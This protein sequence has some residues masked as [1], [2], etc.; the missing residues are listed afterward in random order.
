MKYGIRKFTPTWAKL[1]PTQA[2]CKFHGE[3]FDVYQWPQ[4]MFDG[5]TATFEL[6]RRQDTVTTIAI[7]GDKIIV[8]YQTQP[9]QDWFYDYPGGRHDNPN[10]DELAA[11]KRELREE[12][13]MTFKNWKLID[14]KQPYSKMDW[15]IYTFIATD[16]ESQQPQQLDGGE[17]IKVLEVTLDELRE[18]AKLPNSKFL[19]RDFMKNVKTLDDLK[20]LPELYKY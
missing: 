4:E 6:L 11:A 17:K 9:H 20:N 18:L 10:E 7:K 12:S 14:V 8:E 16:F 15:L 5:T 13:G 2:E 3:V 19:E 1:I